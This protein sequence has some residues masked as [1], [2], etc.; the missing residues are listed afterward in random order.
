MFLYEEFEE[1]L[2]LLRR[3]NMDGL[4]LIEKCEDEKEKYFNLMKKNQENCEIQIED[5]E[6]RTVTYLTATMSSRCSLA[7]NV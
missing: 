4:D 1:E 6:T 5:E 2:Q 7:F 3:E